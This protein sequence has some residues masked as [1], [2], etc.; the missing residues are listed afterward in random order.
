V[1]TH[2]VDEPLVEVDPKPQ[3]HLP[4]DPVKPVFCSKDESREEQASPVALSLMVE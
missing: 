1:P 4:G 3:M 2:D